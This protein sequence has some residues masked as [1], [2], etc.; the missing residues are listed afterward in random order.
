MSPMY[1]NMS[2]TSQIGADREDI[3]DQRA[4]PLRPEIHRVGIRQQPVENPRPAEMKERK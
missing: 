4:A 1:Q 3:P 2:D